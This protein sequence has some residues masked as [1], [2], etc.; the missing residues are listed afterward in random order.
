ME[1]MVGNMLL[2]AKLATEL[3][4][5]DIIIG[6]EENFLD[7]FPIESVVNMENKII[8]QLDID[9]FLVFNK[10]DLIMI[11]VYANELSVGR[12][13][14]VLTENALKPF[15]KNI[16]YLCDEN[17]EFFTNIPKYRFGRVKVIE[18]AELKGVSMVHFEHRRPMPIGGPDLV[19]QKY[20]A[21]EHK[22]DYLVKEDR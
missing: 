20:I 18:I 22:D 10:R 14:I 21:I 9:R 15:Y 19:E 13:F 7:R 11:K 5:G 17:T 4:V 16:R 1:F 8:C 3:K 12:E 2:E 6:G